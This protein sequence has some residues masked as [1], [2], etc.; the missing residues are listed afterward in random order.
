MKGG[1]VTGH[2]AS[3]PAGVSESRRV[4]SISQRQRKYTERSEEEVR[5]SAQGGRRRKRF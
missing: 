2:T 3:R 1:E 4:F 5:E